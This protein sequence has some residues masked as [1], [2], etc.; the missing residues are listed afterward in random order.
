MNTQTYEFREIPYAILDGY[1]LTQEMIDDLP[2][3][4]MMR[5]L[6]GGYTPPL[7]VLTK[8]YEGQVVKTPTRISMIRLNN[9][10]TDIM[11]APRWTDMD[12]S[13]FPEEVQQALKIG[14]VVKSYIPTTGTCYLQYDMDI[15]QVIALP[16]KIVNHNIRIAADY[17]NLTEQEIASIMAG[18]ATEVTRWGETTTIGIDMAE[19]SVVRVIKG[20][21]QQWINDAQTER[22]D[23]YNFA[24][25]GCWVADED[26]NLEYIPE[27][28]YTQKMV[29]EQIRRQAS[30]SAAEQ[31]RQMN[32][33]A[34]L[35]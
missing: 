32:N 10:Q 23:K 31:M 14:K 12:L 29:Q 5:F 16:E 8:D 4:V 7:P 21:T 27:S 2:E 19:A 15:R 34:G 11:M 18:Q 35:K 22:L 1:G 26:N 25:Y 28:E 30:N 20:D 6:S 24:L 17:F 13:E 9:G 3:N 33:Q